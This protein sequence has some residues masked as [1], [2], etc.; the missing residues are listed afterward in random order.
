MSNLRLPCPD[1][2][3][4]ASIQVFPDGSFCHACRKQTKSKSLIINV[5]K[6]IPKTLQ[7]LSFDLPKEAR[8]YL[9]KYY[10]TYD[11]QRIFTIGWSEEFQRVVFPYYLKGSYQDDVYQYAWLRD[12][13]GLKQPKWLYL[14][15]KNS[16]PF[17][18]PKIRFTEE[19]AIKY[20]KTLV[21]TED[22]IS[23]I[24]CHKYSDSLALG[25]LNFKK[26]SL[27]K[28]LLRYQKLIVWLDG[29]TAGRNASHKFADYYKIFRDIHE[30]RTK[31]DPKEFSPKEIEEI[32]NGS[33]NR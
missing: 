32:L 19:D 20:F 12:I 25:G 30:I 5:I 23:A 4:K 10:V 33:N 11:D 8:N 31:K 29:D 21:I 28:I 14:G 7:D 18:L 22:V 13:T 15:P 1:C 24:R 9:N 6:K 17:Y 26:E 16:F 27:S 3:D 2:N